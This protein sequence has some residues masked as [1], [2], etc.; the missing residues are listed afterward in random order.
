M[1]NTE[2]L[3]PKIVEKILNTNT[4][5]KNNPNLEYLKV[6]KSRGGYSVGVKFSSN[7]FKVNSEDSEMLK[8]YIT[9]ILRVASLNINEIKICYYRIFDREPVDL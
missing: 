4:T 6:F 2:L 9:N 1:E 5:K 7:S 3:T 8:T